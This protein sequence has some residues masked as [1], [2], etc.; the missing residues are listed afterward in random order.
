[1]GLRLSKQQKGGGDEE[2]FI[3][4]RCNNQG[5][6]KCFDRNKNKK[7]TNM[8]NFY[9]NL[10]C[11]C[12]DGEEEINY[13]NIDNKEMILSILNQIKDK[14]FTFIKPKNTYLTNTLY[15]SIKDSFKSLKKMYPNNEDLYENITYDSIKIKEKDCSILKFK[16]GDIKKFFIIDN[17]H[18]NDKQKHDNIEIS[19]I[20]II[21]QKECSF[22]I[23]RIEFNQEEFH[24]LLNDIYSFM[25]NMQ[26]YDDI[27]HL[28]IKQAN[29]IKCSDKYMIADYD[30]LTLSS[31]NYAYLLPNINQYLNENFNKDIREKYN[32][33]NKTFLDEN[34][35]SKIDLYYYKKS[36]EYAIASILYKK[37]LKIDNPIIE[38][39]LTLTGRYLFFSDPKFQTIIKENLDINLP[40][41]STSGGSKNKSGYIKMQDKKIN[42]RCVYRSTINRKQYC[43]VKG[44]FVH[45]S[46]LK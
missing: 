28:D 2:D 42:G 33:I 14:P 13:N 46:E 34:K 41:S 10:E 8:L 15:Q 27:F 22:D 39:L 3:R 35:D 4:F 26:Q 36:S 17:L 45:I 7:L 6:F 29:I 18:D 24:K 44:I 9:P 20:H 12:Y 21:L 5:S 23:R 11:I 37:G 31:I 38:K 19:E 30:S 16:I 40:S 1:M 43:K 25:K 32:E